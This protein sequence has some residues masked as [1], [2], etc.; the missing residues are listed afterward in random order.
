[1]AIALACPT[2]A[3]SVVV[4]ADM[5]GKRAICPQCR[6][7]LAL[8]KALIE[9]PDW[10]AST[11]TDPDEFTPPMERGSLWPWVFG[12]GVAVAL[13]ALLCGGP[14]AV[15]YFM[16]RGEHEAA[17]L[18][19][20]V[21]IEPSGVNL[22]AGAPPR[23]MRVTEFRGV[24]QVR[25]QLVRGDVLFKN[26]GGGVNNN[27][28]CKEY[29]IDLEAGKTYIID[30]EAPSFDAYLRLGHLNGQPIMEDDD[31]GG[32]LNSRIVWTAPETK[33]Y[34]V[35]ATSLGGGFGPFTLT[36]RES[37]LKKPR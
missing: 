28:V 33:T 3:S 5:A 36:V 19:Q 15:L 12:I 30:L 26:A 16:L 23:A 20:A 25:E 27:K 21:V 35:S 4:S 13:L 2:C 7:Q 37:Q 1:M 29:V 14:V 9:S 6:M 18:A 10:G 32:G 31:S 17:E 22:P 11:A 8:P 24:F 34:L